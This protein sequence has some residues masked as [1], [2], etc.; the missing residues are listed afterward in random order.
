MYGF[1]DRFGIVRVGSTGNVAIREMRDVLQPWHAT[2][3]RMREEDDLVAVD[4]DANATYVVTTHDEDASTCDATFVSSV[5]A[6]IF[7]RGTGADAGGGSAAHVTTSPERDVLLATA[8]CAHERGPFWTDALGDDMV[9][10]WAVRAARADKTVP[11]IA[12]LDFRTLGTDGVRKSG[13][14]AASADALVDAGCDGVRCYAVALSRA[15]GTDVM[16]PEAAHV[17]LYP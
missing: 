4:G 12:A 7:A 9:V 16:L 17:L 11:P 13:T 5:H 1:G 10:A 14:L 8:D 2:A 15:P 6:E 3:F